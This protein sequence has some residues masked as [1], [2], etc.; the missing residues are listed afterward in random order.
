MDLSKWNFL[1]PYKVGQFFWSS[2]RQ[3]KE[4]RSAIDPEEASLT[5]LC[6]SIHETSICDSRVKVVEVVRRP[7]CGTA[8]PFV[9]RYSPFEG[10]WGTS[11]TTSTCRCEGRGRPTR[12]RSTSGR[13]WPSWPSPVRMLQKTNVTTVPT[14]LARFTWSAGYPFDADPPQRKH[15]GVVIDVEEGQLFVLLP[16]YEEEGVA[17]L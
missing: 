10:W 6:V 16:Q 1:T 8:S 12:S 2:G 7:T 9:E 11:S 13:G 4:T 14:V 15:G 5:I 17:E 3:H